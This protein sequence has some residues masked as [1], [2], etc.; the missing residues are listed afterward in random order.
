MFNRKLFTLAIVAGG[1]FAGSAG[2]MADSIPTLLGDAQIVPAASVAVYN[3][4]IHGARCRVRN[5]NCGNYYN[6]YYYQRPWWT[7]GIAAPLGGAF[8]Y[9]MHRHGQRYNYRR[10]GFTYSY[11]GYY[12]ARPWWTT[13]V[14]APIGG[15]VFV[16]DV[17]RHGPRYNYRRP[18]FANYYGGYYYSRPWWTIRIN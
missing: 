7:V 6:G 12:Y 13:G 4:R 5:P 17:R 8:V 11:G 1:L 18:G 2:A 9:D 3:S 10:P 15:G 16:Y 14:V